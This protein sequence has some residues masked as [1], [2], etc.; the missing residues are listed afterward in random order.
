MDSEPTNRKLFCVNQQHVSIHQLT[1]HTQI[2]NNNVPSLGLEQ[3]HEE[4]C[5]NSPRVGS[6]TAGTLNESG[7]RKVAGYQPFSHGICEMT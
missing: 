6:I 7:L 4:L 1:Q 5:S 3:K 2:H